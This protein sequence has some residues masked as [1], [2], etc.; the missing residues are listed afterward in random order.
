MHW[1]C[2]PAQSGRRCL[3]LGGLPP[4]NTPRP[5][6]LSACQEGLMDLHWMRP[7]VQD[8]A[9]ALEPATSRPALFACPPGLDCN[10]SDCIHDMWHHEVEAPWVIAN[11]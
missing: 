10:G 1:R 2:L 7:W 9:A 5:K 3:C 6:A 4:Q 11:S 8:Y